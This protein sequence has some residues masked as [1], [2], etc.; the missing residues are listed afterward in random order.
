MGLK[1]YSNWKDLVF[2]DGTVSTDYKV[3]LTPDYPYIIVK[4]K[5]KSNNQKRWGQATS[6]RK[7]FKTSIL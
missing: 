1:G 2:P 7:K 6:K 5:K 3:R 4:S